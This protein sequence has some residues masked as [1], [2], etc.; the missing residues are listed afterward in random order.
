[1][2]GILF[3]VPAPAPGEALGLMMAAAAAIPEADPYYWPGSVL[4]WGPPGQGKTALAAEALPRRYAGA[5]ALLLE[6]RARGIPPEEVMADGGWIPAAEDLG[7]A[8]RKGERPGPEV[9]SL[10]AMAR[11]A[12]RAWLA[13]R[14]ALLEEAA[15]GWN[16]RRLVR[17]V[18][19]LCPSL[20]VPDLLGVL[21][22]GIRDGEA[23]TLWRRPAWLPREGHGV[24]VLDDFPA[25]S[26]AEVPR[27]AANLIQFAALSGVRDPEAEAEIAYRLPPYWQVVGTGNRPRD[28]GGL[29]RMPEAPVR[30]RALQL[31]VGPPDEEATLPLFADET[32]RERIRAWAAAHAPARLAYARAAGWPAAIVAYLALWPEMAAVPAA[33]EGIERAAFASWRSWEMAA[34]TLVAISREAARVPAGAERARQLAALVL[35]AAMGRE[36]AADFLAVMGEALASPRLPDPEGILGDPDRA[37]VPVFEADWEAARPAAIWIALEAAAAAAY[38]AHARGASVVPAARYLLRAAGEIQRAMEAGAAG[39]MDHAAAILAEM[40]RMPGQDAALM[41]SGILQGVMRIP[42]LRA[43]ILPALGP[44]GGGQP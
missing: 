12:L 18:A 14:E 17:P 22:E 32:E 13:G 19:A 5:G 21:A 44:A 35:E 8:A 25:S 7:M 30:N 27:A 4:L 3:N 24:L 40:A 28:V 16:W 42:A 20:E 9:P 15:R 39:P 29:L 41:Q 6:A 36:V 43:A 23:V 10:R 37:P 31:L 26:R 11:V 33:V 2:D 34:W 1:M 38:R